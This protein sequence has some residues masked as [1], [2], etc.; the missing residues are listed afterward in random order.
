[1]EQQ[2]LEM[3]MR[4]EQIEAFAPVPVELNGE[5]GAEHLD[6]AHLLQRAITPGRDGV[7]WTAPG[8][9][10]LAAKFSRSIAVWST[11]LSELCPPLSLPTW[12]F[13][14]G[15]G[16]RVQLFGTDAPVMTL[17]H[18]VHC[19]IVVAGRDGHLLLPPGTPAKPCAWAPGR[20]PWERSL[21]TLPPEALGLFQSYRPKE[22]DR[23]FLLATGAT[24]VRCDL[25]GDAMGTSAE[26]LGVSESHVKWGFCRHCFELLNQTLDDFPWTRPVPEWHVVQMEAEPSGEYWVDRYFAA[27]SSETPVGGTK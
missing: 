6:G 20:A 12:E 21:A 8:I 11:P 25:C 24:H 27:T 18:R 1:M 19:S 26:V 23:T 15:E 10:G 13:T 14:I 7:D 4:Y 3:C 5:C 17:N 2:L 9:G 16:D 22:D